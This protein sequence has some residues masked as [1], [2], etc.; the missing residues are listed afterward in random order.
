MVNRP[1]FDS[2]QES[3]TT[4][5]RAPGWLGTHGVRPWHLPMAWD[6]RHIAYHLH[7]E[8]GVCCGQRG[9]AL[10]SKRLGGKQCQPTPCRLSMR[11]IQ[12]GQSPTQF[13]I[14]HRARPITTLH[15]YYYYTLP[16]SIFT[17]VTLTH[18]SFDA[19]IFL[20]ESFSNTQKKQTQQ[21][22]T[23]SLIEILKLPMFDIYIYIQIDRQI[24]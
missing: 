18:R 2:Q 11:R 22:F 23:R 17:S 1:D 5:P 19:K 21:G 8:Q 14:L 6:A 9:T 16:L 12:P 3:A 20:T 10:W 13:P 7:D 15:K 4:S 24:D